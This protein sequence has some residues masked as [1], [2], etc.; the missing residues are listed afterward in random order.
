M[1]SAD[2]PTPANLDHQDDAA[3]LT[4]PRLP[5]GHPAVRISQKF[6]SPLP[7]IIDVVDS[8]PSAWRVP[9][10]PPE[11]PP[12][13]QPPPPPPWCP[14]SIFPPAFDSGFQQRPATPLPLGSHPVPDPND[15]VVDPGISLAWQVP[16]TDPPPPQ[17]PIPLVP[18]INISARL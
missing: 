2:P 13:P 18:S 11:P 12:P 4:C 5:D 17:P 15:T 3:T 10:P 8:P 6:A 9:P 1:A 16:P 7:Q 14:P